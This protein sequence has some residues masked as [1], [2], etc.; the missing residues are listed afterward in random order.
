MEIYLYN[1]LFP[2][3]SFLTV[4][5]PKCT[6]IFYCSAPGKFSI[7]KCKIA[8]YIHTFCDKVTSNISCLLD[9][10]LHIVWTT[11]KISLTHKLIY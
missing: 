5:Q 8:D 7:Y 6:D 11:G 9:S 10:E 1:N 3:I 4:A 2:F